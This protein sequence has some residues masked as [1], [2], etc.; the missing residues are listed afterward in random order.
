MARYELLDQTPVSLPI[1]FNRPE[2]LHVRIQREVMRQIEESRMENETNEDAMDFMPDEV[3]DIE[4]RLTAYQD[5]HD[6]EGHFIPAETPAGDS[7]DSQ[8]VEK[9]DNVEVKNETPNP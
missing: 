2:P 7:A 4:D 1:K 9:T 8:P 6:F 3:V 5:E